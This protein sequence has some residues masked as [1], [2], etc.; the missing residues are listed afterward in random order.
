M[1]AT[2]AVVAGVLVVL[3]VAALVPHAFDWM[4]PSGVSM[5]R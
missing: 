5:R 2:L 4:H 1:R 3:V